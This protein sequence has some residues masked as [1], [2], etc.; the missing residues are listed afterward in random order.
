MTILTYLLTFIYSEFIVTTNGKIYLVRSGEE[1][2]KDGFM[3]DSTLMKDGYGQGV[4]PDSGLVVGSGFLAKHETQSGPSSRYLDYLDDWSC[5][6]DIECWIHDHGWVC[7]RDSGQCRR[8]HGEC[9][10]VKDCKERYGLMEENTVCE[11]S[12]NSINTM[13]VCMC[14]TGDSNNCKAQTPSTSL[15]SHQ[16]YSQ[17]TD[18][19][20]TVTDGQ[21]EK[22][23]PQP[24]EKVQGDIGDDCHV[25]SGCFVESGLICVKNTSS[26]VGVCS[27]LACTQDVDCVTNSFLPSQCNGHHCEPKQC[28]NDTDCPQNMACFQ[29]GH[30]KTVYGDSC[31]DDCDCSPCNDTV[32][33]QDKCFCEDDS[34]QCS[35]SHKTQPEMVERKPLRYQ[36]IELL[37]STLATTEREQSTTATT[38]EVK[39]NTDPSVTTAIYELP[40][41]TPTI[42]YSSLSTTTHKV[43]VTEYT[44]TK[45]PRSHYI[46][47]ET[48]IMAGNSQSGEEEIHIVL[49]EEKLGI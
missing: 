23:C 33:F 9:H 42:E 32:C 12:L 15:D 21:T 40:E 10:H 11:S 19:D 5:E 16:D 2:R 22:D 43:P 37:T 29:D 28:S 30:C 46:T 26:S 1:S 36:E 4:N 45:Q 6:D 49:F 24:T 17:S 20:K 14:R 35:L 7:H 27:S 47:D 38:L 13:K 34:D 3:D 39:Q 31:K 48:G 41:I 8:S 18:S 25:H 44:S